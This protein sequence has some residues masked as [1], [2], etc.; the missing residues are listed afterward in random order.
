MVFSSLV[1]LFT[2]LPITLLL[3]YLVPRKG[4]NLVLLLCSLVFYAWGEPIYIFLM[5]ISILFNYFSGLDIARKQ[6]KKKAV[7]RSLIY[8]V[9]VNI[10]ILGFFKYYGFIIENL[11]MILPF[12]IPYR[13]LALPIGISFYTFQTLSYLVDLYRGKV[14]VQTNLISF[15]TYVTMFP[16]L[17]AG[18]IVRYADIDSQLR[19]RQETASK[20]GQGA[21]FF[22]IGLA[23]KVLIANTIGK[24]YSEVAAMP[25]TD[26]SVLTAW[27]GCLAFTFQIYFDFSGYSDMAVGLG[28]M[29]GFEF[30]KNFDYPYMSR[31]VTEFWRRWHISLGSWFREYVYIPLG[32][33]RVGAIKNVRNLSA[34]WF[35]TGLWHGASWTFVLWGL[36]YGV[37]LMI[38]KYVTGRFL[39]K[40]PE[41]VRVIYNMLLVMIGWVLFFSPDIASALSY[42]GRMFGVS[43]A[44]FADRQALYLI[45]SNWMLILT[46]LIGSTPVMHRLVS[47][48]F[49]DE[50]Q[51]RPGLCAALYGGMFLLSV[52]YLVAEAYNPFLYFRF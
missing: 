18:P 3:Y 2:F 47:V 1:F 22:L 11:N 38:E 6:G 35:L 36:Y 42:L 8:A 9:V 27:M 25:G 46:A 44:G 28:K 32:G 40:L 33:N 12:E 29:F 31:S 16:Q 39:E 41:G 4:K 19:N 21:V 45:K 49:Y 7:R 17:I 26:V 51:P 10:L 20:F 50:E 30:R 14:E 34:V 48:L 24:V 23:K 37:I 15:G 5:I 13:S 52:A 43:A